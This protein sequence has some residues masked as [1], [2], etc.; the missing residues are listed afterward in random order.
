MFCANKRKKIL[1][2]NSAFLLGS[3]I[4]VNAISA[5]P[6]NTDV[7]LDYSLID[8]VDIYS[9]QLIC[10]DAGNSVCFSEL[11][12]KIYANNGFL[13]IWDDTAL[14]QGLFT[15]LSALHLSGLFSGANQRLS[16]LKRLEAR[17]DRRGFDILAT[18]SYLALMAIEQKIENKPTIL[19]RHQNVQP[20]HIGDIS[21]FST[22]YGYFE[23]E[24]TRFLNQVYA[25][26]L[27]PHQPRRQFTLLNRSMIWPLI[28]INPLNE[29]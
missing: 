4:Y 16:E 28:V 25:D 10:P 13:P 11:T 14:R 21:I 6:V 5:Q 8:S 22:S 1:S 24:Q 19:F 23:L 7:R 2:V 3:F 12:E 27:L 15:K 18:D 26:L 20:L 9:S 29:V 17:Q